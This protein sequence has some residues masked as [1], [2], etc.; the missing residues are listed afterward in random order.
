M[1]GEQLQVSEE[2]KSSSSDLMERFTSRV[3]P[4]FLVVGCEQN[5]QRIDGLKLFYCQEMQA[6][7]HVFVFDSFS[8]VFQ[9]QTRR[10][11]QLHTN[12]NAS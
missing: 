10:F 1:I 3:H 9:W 7:G 8:Q 4:W 2:S 5:G 6:S 12:T 11:I